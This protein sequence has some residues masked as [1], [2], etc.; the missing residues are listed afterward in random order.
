[1]RIDPSAFHRLNHVFH[2][3]FIAEDVVEPLLSFDHS[4][5]ASGARAVTDSHHLEIVGVRREG[6]VVG[7]ARAEDLRDG[8][9]GDVISPVE[10]EQT[11][12]GSSPL[13]RVVLAL[14]RF[15]QVFVSWLGHIGGI[16]IRTD[17]QKPPVRMWLF[18]MITLIEMRISDLIQGFFGDDSW[19]EYLSEG[20]LQ[21]AITLQKERR[22]IGQHVGTLDCLQLSDKG[23]I[24]ARNPDLRAQTQFQS[25]QQVDATVKGLE[26]L[27]NNLAHSQ[28]IVTH[29]W[30]TIVLLATNLDRVVGVSG[31]LSSQSREQATSTPTPK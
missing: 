26:R 14:D 9:C 17:M 1:M 8:A 3:S 6:I 30:E 4:T 23:Q 13:A 2:E 27:R 15:E 16:I 12:L 31:P 5:G 20:R 22:R 19:Q 24:L 29:D 18:G 11:L 7:F 10:P 25:R 21:K 28:D